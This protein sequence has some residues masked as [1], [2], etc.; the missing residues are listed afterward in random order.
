[1]GRTAQRHDRPGPGRPSAKR[2]REGL[3][4]RA[5]GTEGMGAHG[6]TQAT[7]TARRTTVTGA[8]HREE[9]WSQ[10]ERVA[11]PGEGHWRTRANRTFP[12]QGERC[13]AVLPSTRTALARGAGE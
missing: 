6:P 10:G 8:A 11:C 3:E 1:M 7:E 12:E 2:V 4:E 13:W 5:A 9:R